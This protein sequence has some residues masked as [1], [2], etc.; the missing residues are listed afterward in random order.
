M[1]GIVGWKSSGKTTLI[2]RLIAI[3]TRRGLRIATIKHSHHALR[4][5]DG[6]TD[7]ER[8]AR[9]G[10]LDVAVIGTEQWE[11]S[12]QARS[13]PVPG[14]QDLAARLGPAD[15]ILVEGF[16]SAPIPKIEVRRQTTD[17]TAS[18]HQRPER[19]RHRGR[20]CCRSG[21]T[22]CLSQR[23]R[24]CHR[25]LHLERRRASR[26]RRRKLHGPLNKANVT[27]GR[28]RGPTPAKQATPAAP[29]LAPSSA[30]SG[31]PRRRSTERE[32][33]RPKT[34]SAQR[35]GGPP[36]APPR[37]AARAVPPCWA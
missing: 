10:A 18:R 3:L 20:S 7:G 21:G 27:C 34:P 6:A 28:N 9:A 12:G 1:I 16:K 14:L 33:P 31:S 32:P 2:E 4:P 36:P 22:A 29:R 30:A 5:R 23:R 11:L 17:A 19:H 15:L 35:G 26:A 8:H 13:P 24:R 37:E 25:R